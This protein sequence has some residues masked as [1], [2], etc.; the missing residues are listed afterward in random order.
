MKVAVKLRRLILSL[1]QPVAKTISHWY[2]A[3]RRPKMTLRD[4]QE[5]LG[6]IRPG[7]VLISRSGGEFTNWF[8]P[9]FWTHAALYAAESQIVEAVSPCV[10]VAALA[11]FLLA[12]DFICVLRPTFAS[13]L[14]KLSAVTYAKLQASKN[15]PYDY[16]F[17]PTDSAFYCAEIIGASYVYALEGQSPFTPRYSLG[18]LTYIPDDFYNAIHKFEMVWCKKDKSIP[19]RNNLKD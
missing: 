19:A 13:E 5:I 14:Q 10:R 9:G 16:Q 2:I 11:E 4:V 7:D 1:F 12:K 3:F 18:V 17:T 15:I 6:V 8:I